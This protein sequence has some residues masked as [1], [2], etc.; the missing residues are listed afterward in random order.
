MMKDATEE[1][2]GPLLA[3]VAEELVGGGVRL[4]RVI[5][6]RLAAWVFGLHKSSFYFGN[7]GTQCDGRPLSGDQGAT[8]CSAKVCASK[9]CLGRIFCRFHENGRIQETAEYRDGG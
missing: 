8:I 2:L 7:S 4:Q 5:R 3:R 6:A 1:L 9:V